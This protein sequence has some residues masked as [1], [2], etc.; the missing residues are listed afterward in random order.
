[1]T[2]QRSQFYSPRRAIA[3]MSS[4]W[5]R[6]ELCADEFSSSHTDCGGIAMQAATPKIKLFCRRRTS[7]PRSYTPG[8]DFALHFLFLPYAACGISVI[9]EVRE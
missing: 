8:F 4:D 7:G 6:V 1:M 3:V 5:P 9:L 2:Y